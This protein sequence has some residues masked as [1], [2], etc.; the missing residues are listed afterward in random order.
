MF[1]KLKSRKLWV[2]AIAG[3]VVTFGTAVGFPEDAVREVV[4]IAV[5]YVLG[6]GIADAGAGKSQT[7]NS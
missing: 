7:S 3:L 2:T 4:A 5:A 1:E 6:Q